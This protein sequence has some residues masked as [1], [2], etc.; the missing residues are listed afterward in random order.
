MKTFEY[1]MS[2]QVF[3][4][5]L[6]IWTN[7]KNKYEKVKFKLFLEKK[8]I[9]FEKIKNHVMTFPYWFWFGNKFLNV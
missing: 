6:Q 5:C 1:H 8:I 7:V 2:W 3:F 9:R 4:P